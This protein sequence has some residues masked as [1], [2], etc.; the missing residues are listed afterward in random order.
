MGATLLAEASARRALDL[1]LL[2]LWD[3]CSGKSM[4]REGLARS[5][6]TT[7][8][9]DGSIETP[10]YLYSPQTVADL[11][12][13]DVATVQGNITAGTILVLNR[14]D[15][16]PPRG[17]RRKLPASESVAWETCVG[18]SDMLDVPMDKNSVPVDAV[19][20]VVE[21]VA[22]HHA[23]PA[24]QEQATLAIPH[25]PVVIS[26]PRTP[27][28]SLTIRESPVRLGD[29][30]LFGICTEPVGCKRRATVVFV[31]VANDRQT[32]PGR[33]WVDMARQ[34]AEEGFYCVRLSQSGTGDSITLPGQTF[35]DLYCPEWLTDLP[36]A[37]A[38]PVLRDEQAT[39][40][41]RTALIS[42]C[43][44]AYSA[45]EAAMRIPV[46]VVYPINVILTM[47]GTSRGQRLY[48]GSRQIARPVTRAFLPRSVSDS[49]AV[50]RRG[51]AWRLYRQIAVWHAPLSA[52]H[53]LVRRGTAVVLLMSPEDGRH[54]W[55]SVFWSG[56]HTWRWRRAGLF[57]LSVDERID[58]PLMTQDGQQLVAT[59]IK[60][61]LRDRFPPEESS[62]RPR[63]AA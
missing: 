38:D 37:L 52:V 29:A 27:H 4:L 24:Q 46:A 45:L 1:E 17:L 41:E 62:C 6:S 63:S 61:D 22:Q 35:G 14:D 44:G 9:S 53:N 16:P 55:E 2:V 47:Y 40:A 34:L 26:R 50:R 10:G 58:H 33:R 7:E 25:A 30:G 57:R 28:G 60:N 49:A 54:F 12:R 39:G 15:R 32:G 51:I 19:E 13:L 5:P 36:D 59:L 48:N 18:L 3:P 21:W 56:L 43:S 23:Q 42:L 11:R 20:Q 31:N 8:R